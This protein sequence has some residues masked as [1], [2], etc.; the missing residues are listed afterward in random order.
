MELSQLRAFYEI[1]RSGSFSKGAEK[2]HITQPALSRQIESL[3]KSVG[4]SLFNRHSRGVYLSEAGRRLFEYVEQMLRL[5]DEADR[6]LQEL[7]GLHIGKLSIGACTT[8]G[9]YLLP[10]PLATFLKQHPNIEA[11]L[12]LGSSDEIA[13][14]A[15]NR[16][17][18]LAFI[19]GIADPPGLCIEPILE[20]Q[21]LFLV[22][23]D[24]PLSKTTVFQPELL[25]KEVFI[26]RELGSATRKALEAI[27][28]RV[29]I[30]P[31]RVVTLGDTEAVKRA[32]MAGMGI[33]FLS[34][35]TVGLELQTGLLCAPSFPELQ[36]N[37]KLLCIYP[38]GVHLS[39][40]ALAFLSHIKKESY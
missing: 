15:A 6:T 26:M 12:E 20:D 5:A 23:P 9:S 31:G 11:S 14:R 37:R 39:P 16:D 40:A 32:V 22:C 25:T 13:A 8:M 28:E 1:A 38:K 3:E 4:I 17:F 24:H 36:M 7:Q 34:R 29:Q 18:D 27:L 33:T 2:L 35:F 21:I 30:K 10:T 19:A